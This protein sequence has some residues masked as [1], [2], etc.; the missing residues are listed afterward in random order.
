K[1]GVLMD[2]NA[3]YVSATDGK[4]DGKTISESSGSF[5]LFSADTGELVWKYDTPMMNWPMML[6]RDGK[7]VFGGSD[8]GSVYYWKLGSN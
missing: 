7:S 2:L 3:T 6:A 8:D 1:P 4:P 5:Y